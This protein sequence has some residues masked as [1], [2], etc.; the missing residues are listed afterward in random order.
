MYYIIL[1]H[2]IFKVIAPKIE[3]PTHLESN[4]KYLKSEQ[5]LQGK[6]DS[7]HQSKMTAGGA[8]SILKTLEYIT[9]MSGV[10]SYVSSYYRSSYFQINTF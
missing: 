4:Y 1:E 8:G 3:W 9:K 2:H 6:T 7:G 10:P 5:H